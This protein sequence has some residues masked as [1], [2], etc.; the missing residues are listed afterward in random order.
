MRILMRNAQMQIVTLKTPFTLFSTFN[1]NPYTIR[2]FDVHLLFDWRPPMEEKKATPYGKVGIRPFNAK[3]LMQSQFMSEC[4]KPGRNK[5]HFPEHFFAC[6][7]APQ[8]RGNN[9]I[10]GPNSNLTIRSGFFFFHR[11]LPFRHYNLMTPQTY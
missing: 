2:T 5:S 8:T 7:F 10:E 1:E 3:K 4:I 9:F 6:V 11:G